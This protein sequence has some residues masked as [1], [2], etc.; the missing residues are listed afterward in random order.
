M[1]TFEEIKTTIEAGLGNIKC[2]TKL[3]N[4]KLVNV[5]SKEVY[6]TDIYIKDRRIV[7]IEKSA[8]LEAN[9]TI[10]CKGKYAV[11]GLIDTHVH[12]E[13]TL[14]SPEALSSVIVPHGTTTM[15]VDLME[16]ANVAGGD[17]IKAMLTSMKHLPYRMIIE[18]S[19]RVPTAPGLETNGVI[20][21]AEEVDEILAWEESG[22]LG[23]IDPSKILF[24]R[25]EYLQKIASTLQRRKIVNGHAIGRLGQELNVYA[26]AGVS[27]DHEC[28][29]YEELIARIRLGMKVMVR[30]GSTERNVEG[31]IKG[32][33]EHK[34]STE[35]LIFCTDDKHASEIEEEGHINYNINKSI[36]LGVDP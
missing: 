13:S 18:V 35:N 19:S 11:P 8:N 1:R 9:K 6:E 29:D 34:L 21:G 23:E 24:S 36:E 16:I 17:G 7:S 15:C 22:S 2:D 26:S 14:L 31:L 32:V 30:E 25:D 33:V 10:D 20:M 4:V 28:V 27:D 5:F 12:F 3:E